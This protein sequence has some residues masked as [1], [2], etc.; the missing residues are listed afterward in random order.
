MELKY[1]ER[2]PCEVVVAPGTIFGI[3]VPVET[4][5]HAIRERGLYPRA[6]KELAEH[7]KARATGWCWF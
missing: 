5:I 4:I 7:F 3:G 2:T 6:K 1:D